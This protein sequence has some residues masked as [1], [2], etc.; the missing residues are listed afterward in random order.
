MFLASNSRKIVHTKAAFNAFYRSTS[1]EL[2]GTKEEDY[3]I[4]SLLTRRE[5]LNKSVFSSFLIPGVIRIQLKNISV[6]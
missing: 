5:N 4:R 1:Y 6:M 2:F 3:T